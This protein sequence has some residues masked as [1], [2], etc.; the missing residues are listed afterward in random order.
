MSQTNSKNGRPALHQISHRLHGVIQR[1]RVARAVREKDSGR[2][3]AQCFRGGRP[4]GDDLH[5]ETMLTQAAQNIVFHAVVESDDGNVCRR[6]RLGRAFRAR[7]VG[8][9]KTLALRVRL[10]PQERLGM[11]HGLDVIHAGQAGPGFG[12]FDRF[13]RGDFACGDKSVERTPHA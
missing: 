13:L 4:R 12:A 2:F 7:P 6:Q 10:I 11:G 8:Q 5:L 3:V 1:G 9:V